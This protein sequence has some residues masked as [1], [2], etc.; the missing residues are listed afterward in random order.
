MLIFFQAISKERFRYIS[1]MTASVI[2]VYNLLL[3]RKMP[4]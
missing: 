2:K 1:R 4:F 3:E